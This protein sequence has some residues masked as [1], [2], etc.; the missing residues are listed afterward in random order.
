[1][2]NTA[3]VPATV[4]LDPSFRRLFGNQAPEVNSGDPV[5]TSTW[6]PKDG[7]I[8]QHRTEP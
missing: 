5:K 8:L 7:I 6:N 4:N 3:I 2:I 1:L